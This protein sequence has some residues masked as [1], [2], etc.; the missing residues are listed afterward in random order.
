MAQPQYRP[1]LDAHE[2]VEAQAVQMRREGRH[3]APV[4][5]RGEAAWLKLAVPQP[6]AWRYQLL[7]GAAKAL[8][9]PAIQPVRPHGGNVGLRIEARRIRALGVAQLRAPTI[10]DEADDWLLLSDL[11]QL[12]L[13]SLIRRTHADERIQWWQRGADYILQAHRAGQYL[14]QAFARNFVWSDEAGL[15]AIDFEDDALSAMSL[16]NAQVRDWLP[17]LF[18]S[19]LY[20]ED[21][22]PELCAALGERIQQE[23][24]AVRSGLATALRR[25]AWLRAARWLPT[26]MQRTDVRKTRC[27]GDFARLYAQ[28]H[29]ESR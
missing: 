15:G 13:E 16:A 26:R 2:A 9:Q 28:T 3:I 7:A 8:G 19:A 20:F 1:A 25:T 6:P 5:W 14:S 29:R 18:S 24:P 10:L 22:L 23:P 12:T 17:Y 11:G 4:R 21:R 27:F